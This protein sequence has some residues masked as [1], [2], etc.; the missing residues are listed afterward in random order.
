MKKIFSIFAVFLIFFDGSFVFASDAKESDPFDLP[1]IVAVENK[2]FNPMKDITVQ[3]G[4]LP[5][6]AFYKAFSLGLSYTQSYTPYLAWE[7]FNA[8]VT[9]VTDTN[10]KTDLLSLQTQPKGL[11]DCVKY[12]VTSQAVYTPI[13]S[14]NLLFNKDV[15]YADWSFVAGLG[16][17]GYGSGESAAMFG[18]GLMARFFGANQ[19][20]YKLDGRLYYQTAPNKSSDLLLMLNIGMAFEIGS[21]AQAGRTL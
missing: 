9:S 3:L 13:Y 15:V 8:H 17:V 21:K 16:L 20:S 19:T 4:V 14:K 10:L 7:I 1:Q 12:Y 11:L 2:K 18:G 5:L 6:D